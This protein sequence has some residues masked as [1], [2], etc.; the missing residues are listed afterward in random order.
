MQSSWSTHRSRGFT[1]VTH[2]RADYEA[3]AE[4]YRIASRA[5]AGIIIAVRRSVTVLAARLLGIL[6]TDAADEIADVVRY[7]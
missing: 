6:D 2:N 4:Q 7:I 5:H 3:L 1:L